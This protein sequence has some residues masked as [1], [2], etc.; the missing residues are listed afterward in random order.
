MPFPN[1]A[2]LITNG[3]ES[4]GE[5]VLPGI[6][7]GKVVAVAVDV[8][9]FASEQSC[10]T[11]CTQGV[12]AKHV[13]KNGPFLANSV[14]IGCLDVGA[15]VGT[16]GIE[17]VIVRKYDQDIGWGHGFSLLFWLHQGCIAQKEQQ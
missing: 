10:A 8:A 12:G 6:E 2:G 17:G 7:Y 1:P 15:A 5:H 13:L 4:F 11:G 14:N 16:D 3:L 9:Q